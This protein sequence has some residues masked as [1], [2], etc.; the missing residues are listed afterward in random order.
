MFIVHALQ[1]FN[2]LLPQRKVNIFTPLLIF[3]APLKFE[4]ILKK[5]FLKKNKTTTT[6]KQNKEKI[7]FFSTS[8]KLESG[9]LMV[10]GTIGNCDI[11]LERKILVFYETVR[12]R[13][14]LR[15]EYW[16]F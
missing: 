16:S 15:S 6:R 4:N 14:E 13:L 5:K 2:L 3:Y 12:H 10:A 7:Q 8:I 1:K 11:E 9:F